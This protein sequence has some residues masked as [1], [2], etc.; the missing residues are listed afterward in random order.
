MLRPNLSDSAIVEVA[1][2]P[3]ASQFD[4]DPERDERA[5]RKL[6]E[7]FC[8]GYAMTPDELS[9]ALEREGWDLDADMEDTIDFVQCAV[10]RVHT[11]AVKRWVQDNAIAPKISL[12]AD[13]QVK[14]LGG[15][16]H[17]GVVVEINAERATY[18]VCIP[19]KGHVKTGPG[20]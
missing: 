10:H 14:R 9:Q 12:G 4:V 7:I 16:V 6:V 1:L 19:S 2:S 13:V 15:D 20:T 18:L 11:Q 8:N 3:L 5:W 17:P